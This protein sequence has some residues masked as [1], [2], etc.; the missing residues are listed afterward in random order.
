MDLLIGIILFTSFIGFVV[1]IYKGHNIMMGFVGMSLFWTLAPILVKIIL[2]QDSI[3]S[4]QNA[5]QVVYQI[6]PEN[7]GAVL[8]NIFFGAFFG[9]VLLDT[10]IA[11]TI[12]TKSI[13]ISG[14]NSIMVL[15]LIN[16]IT[17]IIFTSMSGSGAV[18]SIA[19]IIL[20]I[21][22]SIGIPK[23]I[24][25]FSF[26][27]AVA[28]GIFANPVNFTQ[29]QA[30]FS[31]PGYTFAHYSNFGY[32]A[33]IIMVLIVSF[34]S[35]LYLKRRNKRTMWSI[36]YYDETQEVPTKALLTPLIPVVG[37]AIFKLP[38]IVC[39]IVASI[40][41]LKVC[42]MEKR[43]KMSFSHLVSKM[44]TEGV[45]DTASM[46]AFWMALS[47]F[48]ASAQFAGPYFNTLFG[49]IIPTSPLLLCIFFATFSIF[50]WF[51]GPMSLIGCGAA[52]LAVLM[53]AQIQ[54]PTSFLYPLFISIMIGMG[55]FD[56]TTS[57]VAWGLSYTKVDA[58]DYMK[59]AVVP[60]ITIA[61]ILEMMTYV[62]FGRF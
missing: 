18:M 52:I 3:S 7:W 27:G 53:Q 47:M 54:L 31:D 13:E 24:A 11:K 28:A 51:R 21:L 59:L 5:L 30:F 39:F 45:S 29:Y 17:T 32:L 37:V 22:L 41:A 14:D 58:K 61:F 56:I 8:V 36:S 50:T 57:W 19:V 2:Q 43:L 12:I 4:L 55:H 42:Q 15:T 26:T 34:F 40:Y 49:N 20:P 25:L 33:A 62:W 44:F 16:L 23:D 46:V 60:G 48:N 38:V 35:A 6:A 10:D 9:R 1:Y